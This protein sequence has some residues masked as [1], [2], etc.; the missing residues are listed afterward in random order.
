M[1]PVPIVAPIPRDLDT[2]SALV[3]A[4]AGQHFT[5]IFQ[6]RH[7]GFEYYGPEVGAPGQFRWDAPRIRQAHQ[8]GVMYLSTTLGGSLL[9]TL[10]RAAHV[11]FLSRSALSAQY[12]L[13][14]AR[15][16]TQ[17]EMINLAGPAIRHFGLTAE[18]VVAD[19]ILGASV[20]YPYTQPIGA[21]AEEQIRTGAWTAASGAPIL[22]IRY[23]SRFDL[24]TVNFAVWNTISPLLS[25]SAPIPLG[26]APDL[27]RTLSRLGVTLLP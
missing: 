2:I 25:W 6:R 18:Q 17:A 21:L 20:P 9:E 11:P 14:I 7:P 4:D 27:A 19:P 16:G 13:V 1:W 24:D 8:R 15:L 26:D 5:R 12:G 3:T 22:G 23:R 10:L